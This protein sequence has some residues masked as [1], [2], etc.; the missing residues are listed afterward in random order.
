MSTHMIMIILLFIVCVSVALGYEVIPGCDPKMIPFN[1][2]HCKIEY[3]HCFKDLKLSPKAFLQMFEDENTTEPVK[4]NIGKNNL[5]N[6]L[7]VCKVYKLMFLHIDGGKMEPDLNFSYTPDDFK[8][9]IQDYMCYSDNNVTINMNQFRE[10]R[11]DQH[12][13]IKV[14]VRKL[15]EGS[16]EIRD[17]VLTIDVEEEFGLILRRENVKNSIF[18]LN[19]TSLVHCSDANGSDDMKVVYIGLGGSLAGVI[20]ICLGGFLIYRYINKNKNTDTETKTED[21]VHDE[22]HPYDDPDEDYYP[23]D[24]CKVYTDDTHNTYYTFENAQ[25]KREYLRQKEEQANQN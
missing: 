11:P 19:K 7:S 14:K 23:D 12:C 13:L 2:T 25:E 3:E 16:T 5:V 24:D 10:E 15:S 1:G 18:W 4:S 17:G 22:D 20:V 21:S 9:T 6:V 8:K